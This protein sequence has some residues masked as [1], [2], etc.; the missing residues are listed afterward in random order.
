MYVVQRELRAL[1]D[2]LL[3]LQQTLLSRHRETQSGASGTC[4]TGNGER[5]EELDEEIPSD[6]GSDEEES[7]EREGGREGDNEEE[8]R[9][10]KRRQRKRKC[11][12]VRSRERRYYTQPQAPC[13]FTFNVT[14]NEDIQ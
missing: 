4:T 12:W 11:P 6:L 3:H 8:G 2:S 13:V 1:L 10:Q 14:S 7:E 5:E 9:Q